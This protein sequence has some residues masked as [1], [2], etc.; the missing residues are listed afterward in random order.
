MNHAQRQRCD[1]FLQEHPE[2]RRSKEE[3]HDL[4]AAPQVPAEGMSLPWCNED[5]EYDESDQESDLPAAFRGVRQPSASQQE[6]GTVPSLPNR[7]DLRLNAQR[8]R[9]VIHQPPTG[10]S[11]LSTSRQQQNQPVVAQDARRLAPEPYRVGPPFCL[12]VCV[13]VCVYQT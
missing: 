3:L 13:C 11:S 1:V 8:R 12:C 5:G 6:S 2:L 10:A 4:E 7:D 9:V